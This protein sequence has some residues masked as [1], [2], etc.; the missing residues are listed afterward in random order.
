MQGT[1]A[2]PLHILFNKKEYVDRPPKIIFHA[3]YMIFFITFDM[4][5]FD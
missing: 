1:E 5:T 2:V 3:I 4:S